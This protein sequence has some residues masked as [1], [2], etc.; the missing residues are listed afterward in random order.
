MI[1]QA[2]NTS[3]STRFDG[4]LFDHY[5]ALADRLRQLQRGDKDLQIIGV[6]SCTSGEGVS[7]V[8]ANLALTAASLSERPV[9]LIDANLARP[10]LGSWFGLPEGD[11]LADVL[12]G[13]VA[14]DDV[15]HT[16]P[17]A[18][19]SLLTAGTAVAR[20]RASFDPAREQQLLTQVRSNF[21][22]ILVDLPAATQ[23]SFCWSIAGLL[24]GV[25]LVVEAERIDAAL[26]Q[27]VKRDLESAG[28]RTLGVVLNKHHDH[29]PAWF[30]RS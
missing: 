14:V 16:T 15:I 13:S 2:T 5:R 6:A 7:T 9:L 21:G 11:G 19:L 26:A 24:G 28:A 1:R 29:L 10:S 18:N 8:T 23:T 27:R 30:G 17:E 4:W 12:L 25:L 3:A 20:T 22:L